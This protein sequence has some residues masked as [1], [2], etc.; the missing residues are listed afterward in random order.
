M[1][2]ITVTETSPVIS[3]NTTSN[4][5]TVTNST[6]NVVVS[7]VASVS[8]EII[9]AALSVTDAGGDGSLT[10][11]NT[12]G[13]FTYTG[14]SA[15]EVRSH[16]SATS[17]ITLSSGVIGIDSNALFTGKTTDDLTEGSTNLYY[18]NA[19]ADARVNLQT[20]TNLDLSS[21][22]TD[23]LSEGSNNKY[24][25]TSGATVNTDALTEGSSNLYF[26]TTRANSAI[27]AYRGQ[28]TTLSDLTVGGNIVMISNTK[29]IKQEV[30]TY[31]LLIGSSVT[32]Q[33]N[34]KNLTL[35][36]GNI[37]IPQGHLHAA[38][39]ITSNSTI[40]TSGSVQGSLSVTSGGLIAGLAL[41]AV[42]NGN[43]GGGGSITTTTG[44]GT[45]NTYVAANS[46]RIGGKD[47]QGTAFANAQGTEAVGIWAG[48]TNGRGNNTDMVYG[49]KTFAQILDP[50]STIEQGNIW[51]TLSNLEG[52]KLKIGRQDGITA[53][54]TILAT[55]NITSNA[56]I[57]GVTLKGTGAL[58]LVVNGNATI[59]GNLDVTG[60]INS[61]TVVD[62][63]VEDRNITMQYGATGTPSANSQ[64]FIDRGDESN[65]YIK[66]DESSDA[67]KFSNDG[68]TEY[69]IPSSTSDLAEGTNLYYTNSR[70]DA[71][72]NAQTGANL[73]LSQKSTSDLAEGTNL[74]Y[75][76]ARFD[77]RLGTKTTSDLAEG[78]NLYYTSARA[79]ADIADYTGAIINMTGNLT[80]TANV[81]AGNVLGTF[82]GDLTGDVTGTATT[83]TT[84]TTSLQ[85]KIINENANADP[86]QGYVFSL[87][88]SFGGANSNASLKTFTALTYNPGNLS[89]AGVLETGGDLSTGNVTLS[90][91]GKIY[92]STDIIF[93]GADHTLS[94][95]A[96]VTSNA[97]I[98]AA[99]VI[100]TSS[101]H[102][103]GA[104]LSNVVAE[105][106]AKTNDD[107][108]ANIFYPLMTSD[109]TAAGNAIPITSSAG[110]K[111]VPADKFLTV[112]DGTNG[113]IQSELYRASGNLDL[114]AGEDKLIHV[115]KKV[116]NVETTILD[117]DTDGYRI[118][119]AD[120][121]TANIASYTG[122]VKGMLILGTATA[123][124][125]TVTT[126]PLQFIGYPAGYQIAGQ[127][128]SITYTDLTNASGKTIEECFANASVF[129]G[130]QN[131]EGWKLFNSTGNFLTNFDRDTHVSSIS[132][133][134]L[135]M[136]KNATASGTTGFIMFPGVASSTQNIDFLINYTVGSYN[137][138]GLQPY[139]T[140][141]VL[142]DTL[143]N[144]TIDKTS[145][146]D[147][148]SLA[149]VKL[150]HVA[151]LEV[152][153]NDY[154][155]VPRGLLIGETAEPDPFSSV[156]TGSSPSG[157]GIIGLTLEHNGETG[158]AANN[159]PQTKFLINNYTANSILGMA[160]T[161][162][163]AADFGSTNV[164]IDNQYLSAPAFNFK[165]LNSSK[166]GANGRVLAN[167]VVGQLV[168]NAPTNTTALDNV[169]TEVGLNSGS[170]LIHP[171]AGIKVRMASDQTQTSNTTALDMYVQSS[172]R[173]SY[174]DGTTDAKGSIPR[175]F[176][177]NKEGNTV[178]A[179]KT[180]GKI[181]L[182]PVRD[183]GTTGTDTSF[184]ENRYA[185]ALHEYHE[186]LGA[187]FLG[188]K[189]G[190]LVEIQPKSGET[191]GSANFNYDSKGDAT[192]RLS[193]HHANNTVKAQWDITN[194]ESESTLI[195]R[196]HTNS[197]TKLEFS[198]LRTEFS[199]SA[200][201]KNY[202]TAQINALSSPEAGDMVFNTD[203]ALVCVY[204]GSAWRK[205]NDAAM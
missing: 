205:L 189:T 35:D 14:P 167:T 49:T 143:S 165:T 144:V 138:E 112:G 11:S 170:D 59:G 107:A 123:G 114:Q 109:G 159:T 182:R 115:E 91:S 203:L 102:G 10:Y 193:S 192:L 28:L 17:P 97:N 93:N 63:F 53:N 149:N 82:I 94:N 6:S 87:A 132:G 16:F 52:Y 64:I 50:T 142:P 61:E 81:S 26:T 176:L 183:Y 105:S 37:E 172:Y 187:G 5:V 44:T 108:N 133:N 201:L 92:S 24:F 42:G 99:N 117:I 188:T 18:T 60:N 153:T 198:A 197:A 141:Y 75:T 2:N 41:Q 145:V 106:I 191:G 122:G 72:V 195:V 70:A 80:T 166:N 38:N 126:L 139:T 22:D 83:A 39:G 48:D 58:G 146:S 103:N 185:H 101:F 89:T 90:T 136:N 73:D 100:A 169:G 76:N 23:N 181:T 25:T 77:T 131:G 15:S 62:L 163:W 56:N 47:I 78:T 120:A 1:A 175:T 45:G 7:N 196:D 152:G 173:T 194:D 33:G 55:G 29:V 13:V 162:S 200:K 43:I 21:K 125:P 57:E 111:Y 204:N 40:S 3:V 118:T 88:E 34:D 180:D 74:Y 130:V 150:G 67:W 20:G 116:N 171:P 127:S 156:N 85:S 95:I 32:I 148:F 164:T 140:N 8:Q 160:T 157:A 168:W 51:Y 179:A 119:S 68:S 177:A 137:F 4:V 151:D 174:R 134:T 65:T 69:L 147:S 199:T 184:T 79:D 66:W 190:T 31:P 129:G 178:I 12:T 155:R 86:S 54:T 19:R 161:P 46:F 30:G 104:L 186:F 84:A 96:N 158:Y 128:G 71:R 113:G 135:T 124:S 27:D 9:R 202:T 121:H 154:V 110:L 36:D 98:S